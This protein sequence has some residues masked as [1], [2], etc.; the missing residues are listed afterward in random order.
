MKQTYNFSIPW[1]NQVYQP[2]PV[3][4]PGE[5]MSDII[6]EV[7]GHTRYSRSITKLVPLIYSLAI[8]NSA[9]G[10]CADSLKSAGIIKRHYY[11]RNK[12]YWNNQL[13]LRRKHRKHLNNPNTIKRK[14]R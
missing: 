7:T 12:R 3:S 2:L 9:M 8:A 6:F 14:R 13:L 5:F 1:Y 11:K 4:K 10:I